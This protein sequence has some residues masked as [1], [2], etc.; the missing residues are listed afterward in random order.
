MLALSYLGT[1]PSF[2]S[3]G[4]RAGAG[5]TPDFGAMDVELAGLHRRIREAGRQAAGP[6]TAGGAA[7]RGGAADGSVR[8]DKLSVKAR[9]AQDEVDSVR[10]GSDTANIMFVVELV[11]AQADLSP[12]RGARLQLAAPAPLVLSPAAV[13]LPPIGAGQTATLELAVAGLRS[14]SV[15]RLIRVSLVYRSSGG[16][17]GSGGGGR[18]RVVTADVRLP[19]ALLC[20][21]AQPVKMSGVKITVST[22]QPPVPLSELFSKSLAALGVR[23]GGSGGGG[24]G[25]SGGAGVGDDEALASNSVLTFELLT[26]GTVTVMVSKREGRYRLQAASLAHVALFLDLLVERLWRKFRAVEDVV[27]ACTDPL[28]L[29]SYFAEIDQHHAARAALR[30]NE[31]ALDARA[32]QFR[33][34]QK[35]LL[36]RFKEKNPTPLNSLDLLM[37]ATHASLLAT[38]TRCDQARTA[39]AAAACD[40]GCA[41]RALLTLIR[42][43]FQLDEPRFRIM[44]AALAPP[45]AGVRAGAG[46]GAANGWEECTDAALVH[47]LRTSLARGPKDRAA[48]AAR[49]VFPDNTDNI[50]RHLAFV[51]DRLARGGDVLN[52]SGSRGGSAGDDGNNGDGAAE[53]STSVP[54]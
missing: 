3:V 37:E 52:G 23:D 31:A 32:T 29:E 38:S 15:S 44:A 39:L 22:N 25:G 12:I 6:S 42:Y 18:T 54:A 16:E 7:G 9:V 27:I 33:A 24:E 14:G 48:P 4:L 41:T 53:A 2:T 36:A 21:L 45:S 35:R 1:N 26:G 28:P 34:I 11:R 51:C 47:L 40:L 50:K 49:L 46:A 8:A 20:R 19:L 13:E 30:A 43:Q 17:S 5:K 10:S